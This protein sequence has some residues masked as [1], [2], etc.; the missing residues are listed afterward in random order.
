MGTTNLVAHSGNLASPT[1]VLNVVAPVLQSIAVT[2]TS[3]HF[4][5]GSTLQLTA[6][7]LYS[8]GLY[9][10]ITS[11]VAWGSGTPGVATVNATGLATGVAAGSATITATSGV[12]GNTTVTVTSTAPP[13]NTVTLYP[14]ADNTIKLGYSLTGLATTV[15]SNTPLA[16][17]CA[18]MAV[19]A[20]IYT[21]A[22]QDFVC[23]GSLA[24]FNVSS[25]AGK[26]I[27][28]AQLQLQTLTYGVGY[29]PRTWYVN[30]LANSWSGS[31]VTWNSASYL[32]Y[33][34]YSHTSLNPPTYSNQIF[35]VDETSTVRNWVS[36]AYAN[37]GFEFGLNSLLFPNPM[38]TSLDAFE[39]YSSEDSGGRGPKLI[40]T[41]Q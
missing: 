40:V 28:S 19:P 14:T 16:V 4:G 15:Y 2:P 39:F 6:T 21:P 12:S 17:G 10:D 20:M 37:D 24:Q 13:Q 34:I 38:A 33:Y 29:N 23:Y 11:S 3:P 9:K 36:G 5:Q 22:F 31:S 41:Y 8:N 1:V 27:I 30:A 7:G 35:S 32:Q 18:W 25:L 26:T